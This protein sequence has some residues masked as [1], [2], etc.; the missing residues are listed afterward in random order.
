MA[1]S[2]YDLQLLIQQLAAES[3]TENVKNLVS[4]LQSTFPPSI[5]EARTAK[6]CT[7]CQFRMHNRKRKCPNCYMVYPLK[8][9]EKKTPVAPPLQINECRSCGAV[10]NNMIEL[11]CGCRHCPACLLDRTTAGRR[12]CPTHKTPYASEEVLRHTFPDYYT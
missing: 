7:R 3:Q 5:L 1:I 10:S 6:K 11:S 8:K 4:A 12:F 2:P 9:A